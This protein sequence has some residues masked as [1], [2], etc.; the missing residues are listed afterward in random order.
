[1]AF[2]CLLFLSRAAFESHS[3]FQNFSGFFPNDSNNRFLE[4]YGNVV[5]HLTAESVEPACVYITRLVELNHTNSL[6]PLFDNVLV[7]CSKILTRQT[8]KEGH[9]GPSNKAQLAG[10]CMQ[11]RRVCAPRQNV[12]Q[13]T[14]TGVIYVNTC[15]PHRRGRF[16]SQDGTATYIS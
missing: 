7:Y 6:L 16:A 9:V 4:K 13:K 10:I 15:V 2:W 11:Q 3:L 12:H 1:M 8:T 5:G 14:N